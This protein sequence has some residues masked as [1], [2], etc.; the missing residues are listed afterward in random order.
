MSTGAGARVKAALCE[1]LFRCGA[2]ALV[3]ALNNRRR[4]N[5]V[6]ILSAHRVAD[7]AEPLSERDAA[8]LA[9]GCLSL[10]EFAQRIGWLRRRFHFASLEAYGRALAGGG[11]MGPNTV[12]L[13]FDDGF[14][15]VYRRAYPRLLADGIPF[16][17]FLTTG[18]VGRDPLM[19]S[20]GD[21]RE[22]ARNGAGSSRGGR[23]A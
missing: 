6:C 16:A 14:R 22:M 18:W 23:T 2:A 13:T 11:T 10:P 17:V 5:P 9:R 20:E 21:V 7:P 15:D 12:I 4:G 3:R 8:D 1:L 19:L